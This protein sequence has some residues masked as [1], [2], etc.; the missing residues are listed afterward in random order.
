MNKMNRNERLH[1]LRGGSYKSGAHSGRQRLDL[2]AS[3]QVI[4][5]KQ[6]DQP[7]PGQFSI[8]PVPPFP[9]KFLIA[10]ALAGAAVLGLIY[11]TNYLISIVSPDK[12]S[13][14]G[15]KAGGVTAILTATLG[16]RSAL[17]RR[18]L[19]NGGYG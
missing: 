18:L 13:D 16:S 7:I 5:I 19:V 3:P 1:Y 6:P 14:I 9:F 12:A 4:T 11:E 8:Q 10:S 17:I 2:P 15:I